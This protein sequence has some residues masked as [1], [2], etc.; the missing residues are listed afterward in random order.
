VVYDSVKSMRTRRRRKGRE[1]SNI[2]PCLYIHV[3][4]V[5]GQ[6]KKKQKKIM[7]FIENSYRLTWQAIGRGID[8]VADQ[9][10]ELCACVVKR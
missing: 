7:Q 6:D 3:I 1:G 8:D 2:E 9:L 10:A 5:E 4:E